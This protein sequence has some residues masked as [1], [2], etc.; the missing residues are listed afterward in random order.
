MTQLEPTSTAPR[1][2]T[3]FLALVK[4]GGSAYWTI[5]HTHKRFC[6]EHRP[7]VGDS[8]LYTEECVLGWLRLPEIGEAMPECIRKT[9]DR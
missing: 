4:N 9:V 1:D 2:G 6:D 5:L 3:R 7:W 8:T